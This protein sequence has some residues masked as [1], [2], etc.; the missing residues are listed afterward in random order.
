MDFV[1]SENGVLSCYKSARRL[2]SSV[3]FVEGE[4]QIYDAEL[5]EHVRIAGTFDLADQKL[6]VQP[7][8]VMPEEHISLVFKG[9]HHVTIDKK[10]FTIAISENK[11]LGIKKFFKLSDVAKIVYSH[12]LGSI[13]YDPE[14]NL[15]LLTVELKAKDKEGKKYD[16]EKFIF[17]DNLGEAMDDIADD[18]KILLVN[19]ETGKRECL[20]VGMNVIKAGLAGDGS[21]FFL[22]LDRKLPRNTGIIYCSNKPVGL[23]KFSAGQ[24]KPVCTTASCRSIAFSRD[25]QKFVYLNCLLGG[26]HFQPSEVVQYDTATGAERILV[27]ELCVGSV[28]GLNLPD[29]QWTD[30]IYMT[31]QEGLRSKIVRLNSET[32]LIEELSNPKESW[33]IVSVL[34]G[35]LIVAQTSSVLHPPILGVFKE[36]KL[37]SC[38]D[39]VI[40]AAGTITT[41][42]VHKH[43][44]ALLI[45]PGIVGPNKDNVIM[46]PHG[47]PNSNYV[48]EYLPYLA[49]LL[50]AGY[51]ICRINYT[52]S[53]GYGRESLDL[54]IKEGKVGIADVSDCM[55]VYE[56][57]IKLGFKAVH[58]FGG[59]HGGYLAACLS[60]AH[61]A[62]FKTCIMI[63]PVITMYANC[64]AS[65][66]FDYVYE[67][68]GLE[69]RECRPPEK[70]ELDLFYSRS[71]RPTKANP[72][73]LILVGG[74]DRRVPDFNGLSWYGWLRGL[75][76]KA[77]CLHFPDCNHALSLP[78]ADRNLRVAILDFLRQSNN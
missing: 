72:P 5:A 41:I 17:K 6:Q 1:S 13:D 24:I 71:P 25:R 20:Q 9:N 46:M 10:N 34:D 40:K 30:W 21:I 8:P 60:S 53:Y 65:D 59:S 7:C 15:L 42:Q 77:Q 22:A 70:A 32:G 68:L 36:G 11:G 14:Q 4:C 76:V 43:C 73:T 31:C 51:S 63:N 18:V 19:V 62:A 38:Q 67:N 39:V 3:V 45:R 66:I 16:Q 12:S 69:Y 49:S 23:Y 35:D 75:G 61:P 27:S 33:S 74:K 44:E 56:E 57:L 47:G 26:G 64:I 29:Q 58:I 50:K 55:L 54:L 48:D 37:L 52:G 28:F 78:E 2:S